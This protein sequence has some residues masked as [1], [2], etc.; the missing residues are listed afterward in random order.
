MAVRAHYA[1]YQKWLVDAD[2]ASAYRFHRFFLQHMQSRHAAER[3][4]L[5]SPGHLGA[6]DALFDAY[7]IIGYR[8]SL[9]FDE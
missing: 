5:K 1:G 8:R 3:W 4:V 9:D 6:I 2:M 7:K